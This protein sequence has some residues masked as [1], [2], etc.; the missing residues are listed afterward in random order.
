MLLFDSLHIL[1]LYEIKDTQQKIYV[2]FLF[3][4]VLSMPLIIKYSRK[5]IKRIIDPAVNKSY[6]KISIF[7]LKMQTI[8]AQVIM[9]NVFVYSFQWGW[10]YLHHADF[11][12]FLANLGK[13]DS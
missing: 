9:L 7:M 5:K 13:W 10:F 4:N 12:N 2:V 8:Q 11:D 6:S 1:D 3:I